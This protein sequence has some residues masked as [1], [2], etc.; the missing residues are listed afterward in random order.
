VVARDPRERSPRLLVLG[1][2][3]AQL[4]LL[5]ATRVHGV[6]TAALYRDPAAPGFA[7]ADRRCIVSN[8]DEPAVERLAAALD[9]DGLIAP[10]TDWP[11]AV[12][13]RV[14]EKL[15]LPHPISPATAVLATNKLRQRERLDEAGVPQPRWQALTDDEQPLPPPC[16][17]K[18]PDRQGQK[19]LSLVLHADELPR[20]IQAARASSRSG[21][22]LVEQLVDG[23][24]VTVVA[25][26]AGGEFVPLAVTDR[27]T[28]APPAFGVA[29]AHV[30]SSEHAEA[31]AAVARRAVEALGIADGP[32]YTQLRIGSDGPQVMEVA[33]RLG[34]GHDAELV[35]AAIGVDLNGLAIAAALGKRLTPSEVR[36]LR[37]LGSTNERRVGGAVTR[38]LVAAPGVLE[39]VEVPSEL[40]GVVRVR[41]YREPGYVVTPLRRG[42]DRVGALLAV[43]ATRAQAL[44][45]AES[46][47]DRIRFVTA[48]AEALV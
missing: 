14:A 29:L 20:A 27:L 2:G 15:G 32:S 23:P 7:L 43:G 45:R 37:L 41:I 28:A 12:A 40:E 22:V 24:E 11:V 5:E 1:A 4:G 16:V 48:D 8:E 3:P 25:F 31:A 30:W 17:V 6:W 33:A 9:V 39:S 10:G 34:G 35:E 46:A 47:V 13:A 42:P 36:S 38:F 26:S 21:T 19:G 18:A 44:V